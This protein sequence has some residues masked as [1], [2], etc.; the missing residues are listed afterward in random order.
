MQRQQTCMSLSQL[1]RMI[2]KSPIES[3]RIVVSLRVQC[4]GVQIVITLFSH[5]PL[6]R[7]F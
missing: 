1:L 2:C 3:A 6:F 5:L 4:V 7:E